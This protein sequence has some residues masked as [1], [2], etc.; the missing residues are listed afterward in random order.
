[1]TND[2]LERPGLQLDMF[3][4]PED[5]EAKLYHNEYSTGYFTL[6]QR[7]NSRSRMRQQSFPNRDF[8]AV[9]NWLF[10]QYKSGDAYVSQASF[11]D[12]SRRISQVST[13]S[14][15][16]VD[17]DIYCKNAPQAA[18]ELMFMH[19]PVDRAHAIIKHCEK[20][21]ILKPSTIIHSGGGLYAKW[22]LS[23]TAPHGLLP[24]W[25][26]VQKSL[27]AKFSPFAADPQAM[28]ASRILRVCGS[29][30]SK[31]P[32]PAGFVR[33]VWVQPGVDGTPK[34]YRFDELTA[35]LFKYT[36]EEVAALK[37]LQKVWDSNKKHALNAV[38]SLV[39]KAGP[40]G[41]LAVKQLWWDRLDDIRK[42]VEL[43]YDGKGIPA[44]SGKRN[45]YCWIVANALAYN[46]APAKLRAEIVSE[47]G[48]ICDNYSAVEIRDSA[49]SVLSRIKH[50]N[51]L[52]KMSNRKFIELLEI[53]PSEQ[54]KL[55]TLGG[56]KAKRKAVN[57]GAM[58]FERIENLK[59][60]DYV[61]ET[62]R[63]R[64][65]AGKYAAAVKRDNSADDRA[66][67]LRLRSDG[68]SLREISRELG[69]SSA[70]IHAWFKA[71]DA[72]AE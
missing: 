67:A 25:N 56:A 21:N 23:D 66:M 16:W 57:H 41:E 30:N 52:Y 54:S 7:Q 48:K 69:R 31:V 33:V 50:K 13:V 37:T 5:N 34:T 55:Q 24:A 49:G 26:A 58:G 72:D 8:S 29:S 42:L 62:T 17:L 27:L 45:N 11:R 38:S 20:E 53:K 15:C 44:D 2:T 61:K 10:E 36:R 47:F 32:G 51:D 63:R 1:M 68:V 12:T 70:T 22:L 35:N 71:S 18:K 59:Y 3:S 6:S 40:K 14:A 65:E 60:A 28:D 9:L 4:T 43:R 19:D 64:Q 46:C 39:A